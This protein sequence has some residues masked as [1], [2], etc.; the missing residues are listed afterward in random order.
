MDPAGSSSAE[1]FRWPDVFNKI[2]GAF[3]DHV[4]SLLESMS[5]YDPQER[6]LV[7]RRIASGPP[8][9]MNTIYDLSRPLFD[10]GFSSLHRQVSRSKIQDV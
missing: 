8:H 9:P 3:F 10:D 5:L 1:Y 4:V 7:L 2:R 6:T